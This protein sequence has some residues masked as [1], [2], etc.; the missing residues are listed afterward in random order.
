MITNILE[1][2]E[3]S[4]VNYP[5]KIAF[6]DETE[7]CSFRELDENSRKIGSAIVGKIKH[8]NPVPVFM[9]KGVET[10]AVFM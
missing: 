4:A 3:Q 2:L 9:E 10:I 1:Y 5:E 8:G 6:A 7:S